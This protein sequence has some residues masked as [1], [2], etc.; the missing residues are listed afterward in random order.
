MKCRYFSHYI[1]IEPDILLKN[2]VVEMNDEHHITN[3]FPFEREIEKTEFYSGILM[4]I[5]DKL[6]LSVVS[7]EEIKNIDLTQGNINLN[8]DRKYKILHFEDFII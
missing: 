3:V 4:F 5:E 2:Y 6:P 8:L 1:Y 7:L